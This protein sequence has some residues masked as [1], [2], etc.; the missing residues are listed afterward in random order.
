M[1]ETADP[2]RRDGAGESEN[3][4]RVA[5]DI[6]ADIPVVR[7]ANLLRGRPVWLQPMVL[8]SV[9]IALM[10]LIYFGSIVNPSGHL[11]GL[12]VAIVNQDAGATAPTGKVAAGQE[13]V[14]A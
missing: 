2:H 9:V 14:T 7:A 4:E 5:T 12:P 6:L 10:T 1:A 8:A 11:H 13:I 3:V